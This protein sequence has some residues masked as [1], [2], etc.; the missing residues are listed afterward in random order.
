MGSWLE[1]R[2]S[3][4]SFATSG[5]EANKKRSGSNRSVRLQR[6]AAQLTLVSVIVPCFNQGRYLVDALESVLAQSYPSWQCIVVNDGSTDETRRVALEYV[7]RDPRFRY[8]EQKNSGLSA[9]RNRGLGEMRGS[10]VQF[11][12]ADGWV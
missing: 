5:L 8:L 2:C 11:L 6:G 7:A 1:R 12:D 9:A 3:G 10:H 4:D